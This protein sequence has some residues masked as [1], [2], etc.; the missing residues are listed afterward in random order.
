MGWYF[1]LPISKERVIRN[2]E[3]RDGKAILLT[4]VPKDSPCEAG[5]NSI[6]MMMSACSGGRVGDVNQSITVPDPDNPG[7]EMTI[8]APS[9][10]QFDIDGDGDLDIDDLMDI[11]IPDPAGG[12]GNITVT[13]PPSGVHYPVMMYTPK[14]IRHDTSGAPDLMYL[15]GADNSLRMLPITPER[16]G[17]Y[18]WRC[19][20]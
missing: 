4:T 5:G 14:I 7:E 18:Y 10:P 1:D 3:I 15:P 2:F 6:L 12:G 13:V 8:Q 11:T 9:Q 20:E 19:V 16:L 17:V